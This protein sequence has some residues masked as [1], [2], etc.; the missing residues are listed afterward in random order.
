L[1]RSSKG[2]RKKKP[3]ELGNKYADASSRTRKNIPSA[4]TVGQITVTV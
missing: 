2:D 3:V 1:P 4:S